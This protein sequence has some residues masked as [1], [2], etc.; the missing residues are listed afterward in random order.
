MKKTTI[1]S[2]TTAAVILAAY[3][4]NEPILADTPNQNRLKH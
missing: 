1:L 4:P 2:L 3:V